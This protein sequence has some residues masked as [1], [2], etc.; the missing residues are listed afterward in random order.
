MVKDKDKKK[1]DEKGAKKV[2]RAIK[3]SAKEKIPDFLKIND[4]QI[5]MPLEATSMHSDF[6]Q[7]QLRVLLSLI[8]KLAYKLRE[9]I[10]KK[11]TQEP[12]TQLCI[13]Q[14]D[15]WNF[16]EKG[17]KIF[18]LRLLYKELGVD[19]H[20]YEQLENSLKALASLPISLPYK[21]GEGKSYQ[22]FTN[23][24]DVYIPENQKK[25]IY[26]LVDLKEDVA[27]SLLKVDF[28][29]HYVGFW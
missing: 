28:G 23:F 22:R 9:I 26:C 25:N 16:N 10:E 2:Q 5:L 20:H 29:Y 7:I 14:D 13:F 11:K 24:C 27:N 17:E 4:I 3:E 15:E 19:R 18:R 12:G 21:D 1:K 8:E 6:T